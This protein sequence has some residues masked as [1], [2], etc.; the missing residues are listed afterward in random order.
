[1]HPLGTPA[2][3][4]AANSTTTFYRL[5]GDTDGPSTSA[6]GDS[7]SIVNSVDNLAFRGA[8]NRAATYKAYF[9]FDG[10]G[11]INTV[12][13]LEFRNRFNKALSWSV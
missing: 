10:D 13:N 2:V 4:M 8:F 3:N 6:A 7:E 5:Y 12:D 1:V 9:D 11:F